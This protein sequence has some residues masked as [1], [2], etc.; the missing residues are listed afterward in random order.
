MRPKNSW[1]QTNQKK[2]FREIAFL[3]VLNFFPVQKLIFGQFWNCKKMEFHEK[4]FFWLIWFHEFFCLNFF[5]FSGLLCSEGLFCGEELKRN[6]GMYKTTR[7][8][9][10]KIEHC[11][12]LGRWRCWWQ[13]VEI[14]IGAQYFKAIHKCAPFVTD[15]FKKVD[16]QY[17][18]G[19]REL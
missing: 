19:K 5:K 7:E 1:N 13:M 11:A 15:L 14:V 17:V 18:G 12:I 8:K 6:R 9:L 2:F 10:P 16:R 3:A 4:N